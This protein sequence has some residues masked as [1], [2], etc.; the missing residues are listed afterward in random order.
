MT[1][2]PVNSRAVLLGDGEHKMFLERKIADHGLQDR[3]TL[4]DPTLQ[5][6]DYYR[7]CDVFVMSS[8]YEPLG[9]TL[10]EAVAC[11][12]RIAAFDPEKGV[13]TATKELLIDHAV[14][15]ATELSSGGL[16]SAMARAL[17][18]ESVF[19]TVLKNE[20]FYDRY[21]WERLLQQLVLF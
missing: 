2:I 7:A 16:A 1:Y 10:L 12:M 21:S 3:L 8:T 18:K 6:M 15:Y 13:K 4:L 14:E 17:Q 11:G 20:E 5:I 9:Q 19:K